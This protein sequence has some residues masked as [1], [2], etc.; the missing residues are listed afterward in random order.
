MNERFVDPS[1][2][3]AFSPGHVDG[4]D[5]SP[6]LSSA[7]PRLRTMPSSHGDATQAR[8][9]TFPDAAPRVGTTARTSRAFAASSPHPGGRHAH[10]RKAADEPGRRRVGDSTV[11]ELLQRHLPELTGYIRRR[12]DPLLR[13]R[14]TAADLAQAVCCDIL[15]HIDRFE[16]N[17][18][19]G[20]RRWLFRTAERKVIDQYR[21]HS[22]E[23]RH[24]GREAGPIGTV[25]DPLV[26]L[27][28]V[29]CAIAREEL[30]HARRL[31]ERLPLHYRRVIILSRVHGMSHADIAG[32]L[33]K[34]EGAVR[35]ILYRGLAAVAVEL[36]KGG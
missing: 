9:R 14:E 33:S 10:G 20:F 6:P 19:D 13:A 24:P 26:Q 23:R 21:F 16:H 36:S 17:S 2:G 15:V 7:A 25:R 8:G 31:F 27:T 12:T 35:N 32:R 28:P 4:E 11:A 1:R 30:T 5:P 22:A 34:T 3:G 29:Q 18:E